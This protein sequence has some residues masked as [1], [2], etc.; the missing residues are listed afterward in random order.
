MKY[1]HSVRKN[2]YLD[3]YQPKEF[4]FYLVYPYLVC[5]HHVSFDFL[6]LHPQEKPEMV[7]NRIRGEIPHNI[8]NR[9][10]KELRD[11]GPEEIFK[12]GAKC[13]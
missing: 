4:F 12:N 7:Q 2:L 6:S 3:L 9:H 1:F 8:P 11:R 10:R 5:P 13:L